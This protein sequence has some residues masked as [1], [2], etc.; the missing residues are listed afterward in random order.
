M[1]FLVIQSLYISTLC[2]IVLSLCGAVMLPDATHVNTNFSFIQTNDLKLRQSNKGFPNIHVINRHRSSPGRYVLYSQLIKAYKAGEREI[3]VAHRFGDKE[4]YKSLSN[5]NK[6]QQANAVKDAQGNK[7]KPISNGSSERDEPGPLASDTV[8]QTVSAE[9]AA[10]A[11]M[12]VER[13]PVETVDIGPTFVH[14]SDHETPYNEPEETH[15][16][17]DTSQVMSDASPNTY[18][19]GTSYE[20]LR[21]HSFFPV[22]ED[23]S[24]IPCVGGSWRYT[25]AERGI[26]FLQDRNNTPSVVILP[27]YVPPQGLPTSQLGGAPVNS[28]LKYTSNETLNNGIN[29]QTHLVK[30]K[31]QTDEFH[32][33]YNESFDSRRISNS[34]SLKFESNRTVLNSHHVEARNAPKLHLFNQ[35][36]AAADNSNL[37][38]VYLRSSESEVTQARSYE[39][40][41]PAQEAR[42]YE[43]I[44]PAQEARSYETTVPAH[45]SSGKFVDA[46][47]RYRRYGYMTHTSPRSGDNLSVALLQ[48]T[49]PASRARP[50]QRKYEQPTAFVYQVDCSTKTLSHK[51][52]T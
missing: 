19:E 36:S 13:S 5:K 26:I 12:Q 34:I 32:N 16:Q 3:V 51:R 7:D 22:E 17:E 35:T 20:R 47:H 10:I 24:T 27:A 45:E 49:P 38:D 44:V 1:V 28:D 29:Q 18:D 8:Q 39:T 11:P 41:V 25:A 2:C 30:T 6:Q 37:R 21:E 4:Y 40:I 48:P 14:S 9:S 46:A 15:N 23:H 42:S 33:C 52:G 50:T 31:N 43:T